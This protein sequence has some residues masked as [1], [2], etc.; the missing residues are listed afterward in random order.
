MHHATHNTGKDAGSCSRSSIASASVGVHKK[1]EGMKR[2]KWDAVTSTSNTQ[3]VVPADGMRDVSLP[4]TPPHP[5]TPT[6]LAGHRAALPLGG[7][8]TS[9]CFT[10][11]IE[12]G[13][14]WTTILAVVVVALCPKAG[15]QFANHTRGVRLDVQP[16]ICVSAIFGS[17]I[18]SSTPGFGLCPFN[19]EPGRS[20]E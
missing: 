20:A 6:P 15:A 5:H 17:Q 16:W 7:P 3:P 1:Y 13:A 4:P 11:P 2:R 19:L 10:K 9:M 18:G 8:Q 12:A 14:P